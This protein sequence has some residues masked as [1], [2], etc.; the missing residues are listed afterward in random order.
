MSC[1]LLKKKKCCSILFYSIR[2]DRGYDVSYF[3]FISRFQK[4]CISTF[5]L[6]INV[7]VNVLC[8]FHSFSYR[9]KVIIK[10]ISNNIGIGY[11]I[12]IIKGEYCWYIG[13]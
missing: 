3:F 13:C 2:V 7:Y 8:F 1:K 5:I 10:G 6:K 4:Y 11:S 9:D 12:T